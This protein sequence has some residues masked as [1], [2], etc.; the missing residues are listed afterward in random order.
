MRCWERAPLFSLPVRG[1]SGARRVFQGC[2]I[3]A[4]CM[5]ACVCACL[6]CL[7]CAKLLK[8]PE[9]HMHDAVA[10]VATRTHGV[11]AHAHTHTCRHMC[12]CTLMSV[13]SYAPPYIWD[14]VPR[15]LPHCCALA[16]THARATQRSAIRSTDQASSSS[17][18]IHSSLPR[19]SWFR[20][21][22]EMLV[23]DSNK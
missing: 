7:L 12:T 2:G 22:C 19:N 11:Q 18:A 15:R 10:I 13:P 9:A 8:L 21:D 3:L 17:S 6:R 5:F 23:G 1:A 4:C 20:F 16:A 14:V